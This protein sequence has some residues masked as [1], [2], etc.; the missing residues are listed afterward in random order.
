MVSYEESRVME[1]DKELEYIEDHNYISDI[2]ERIKKLE[3]KDFDIEHFI[4]YIEEMPDSYFEGIWQNYLE[5]TFI[6]VEENWLYLD[7]E[8]FAFI[9]SIATKRRIVEEIVQFLM[10]ILPYNILDRFVI[11]KDLSTINAISDWL[12]KNEADLKSIIA[13]AIENNQERLF[14]SFAIIKDVIDDISKDTKKEK[15]RSRLNA[16]EKNVEKRIKYMQYFIF[17]INETPIDTL[18]KTIL[19]YISQ[20]REI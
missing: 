14:K 12:D 16:I 17:C 6:Y 10:D 20:V 8:K 7:T 11:P 18:K 5:P 4:S 2:C 3:L 19:H 15:Y 1:L 9:D 13:D